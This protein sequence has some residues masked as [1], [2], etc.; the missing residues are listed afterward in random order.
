MQHTQTST[1]ERAQKSKRLQE[2]IICPIWTVWFGKSVHLYY[3][4]YHAEQVMRA[5]T[6]NGTEYE[7]FDGKGVAL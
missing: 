3:T 2:H 4:R 6:L 7:Y 1:S 5:L